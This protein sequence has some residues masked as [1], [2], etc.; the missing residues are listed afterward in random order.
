MIRSAS[1]GHLQVLINHLTGNG[2]IKRNKIIR[3]YM[4]R[5]LL[6]T[7]HFQQSSLF[8]Q[9]SDGISQGICN[10]DLKRKAVVQKHGVLTER[11]I[12]FHWG[13]EILPMNK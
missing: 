11:I 4:Q 13:M 1:S 7:Q 9:S 3:P 6:K 5:A 8:L 10:N 2:K 12:R